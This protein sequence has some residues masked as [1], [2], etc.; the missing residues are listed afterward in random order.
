MRAASSVH[1]AHELRAP[2]LA[3]ELQRRLHLHVAELVVQH[4]KVVRLDGDVDVAQLT[5]MDGELSGD[6]QLLAMVIEQLELLDLV[7]L[8]ASARPASSGR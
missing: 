2:Q 5:R 4:L 8:P 6:A 1:V 3:G 7:R